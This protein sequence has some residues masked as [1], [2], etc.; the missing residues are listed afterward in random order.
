MASTGEVRPAQEQPSV[1]DMLRQP[2]VM[3]V[4]LATWDIVGVLA[5]L[6]SD[7]FLFDMKAEA[8]GVFGGRAFS[9][10]ALIPAIVYLWALRDPQHHR[11]VFWLGLIEQ[12]A[13][14]LS[15]FYHR[16]A[17]DVSW[18]GAIIPSIISGALIFLIFP[19]LFQPRAAAVPQ[20]VGGA[21]PSSHQ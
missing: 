16:G 15:S 20:P 2:R 14:V 10:S 1:L 4:L 11:R 12:V 17:G 21:P 6:L 19:N 3:L 9:A 13:L 8:S 18:A 5:Q 7:S